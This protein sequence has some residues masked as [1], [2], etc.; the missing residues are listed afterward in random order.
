MNKIFVE[1][2]EIDA[3]ITT[4]VLELNEEQTNMVSGAGLGD[5]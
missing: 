5:F 3:T 4:N 1:A 2:T